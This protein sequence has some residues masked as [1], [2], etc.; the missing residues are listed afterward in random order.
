MLF[1]RKKLKL[2]KI[3]NTKESIKKIFEDNIEDS[4]NYNLIYAYNRDFDLKIS[5]YIY[6]SII[7]GYDVDN[8]KLIIMEVDKDFTEVFNIIKLGKKDFTKAVYSKTMDEY[9]IYLNNKKTDKINFS[10]INENYLDT[11]ILA[12]IEQSAEIEDFKDFYTDFKRKPRRI[13][14]K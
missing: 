1:K 6:T 4:F 9:I 14:K 11:D 8:M 13:K 10:L 12:Y 2:E 5:D 7:L 3:N